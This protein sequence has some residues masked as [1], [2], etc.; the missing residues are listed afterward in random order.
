MKIRVC[1]GLF[2]FISFYEEKMLTGFF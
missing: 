2:H 1:D